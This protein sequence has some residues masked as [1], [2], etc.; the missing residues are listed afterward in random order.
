MKVGITTT[1]KE[2]RKSIESPRD[3]VCRGQ[4]EISTISITMRID[5]RNGEK[6][7]TLKMMETGFLMLHS[8]SPRAKIVYGTPHRTMPMT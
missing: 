5:S 2:E 8:K 3:C 7:N 1:S 6:M 4:Y